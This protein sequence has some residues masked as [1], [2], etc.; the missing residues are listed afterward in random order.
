MRTAAIR[1]SITDEEEVEEEEEEKKTFGGLWRFV[2]SLG[3][4]LASRALPGGLAGPVDG[5]ELPN[6]GPY[7]LLS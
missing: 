5:R 3:Q 6:H 2:A 4:R 7:V 1:K